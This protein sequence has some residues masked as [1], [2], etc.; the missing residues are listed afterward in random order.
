MCRLQALLKDD[1]NDFFHIEPEMIGKIAAE[2]Y[3]LTAEESPA[4]SEMLSERR[5]KILFRP[6]YRTPENVALERAALCR[7]LEREFGG[8]R[9]DMIDV[10]P[11]FE[12][13]MTGEF[14]WMA[15]YARQPAEAKKRFRKQALAG[16]ITVL[17]AVGRL[18]P[19]FI[20]GVQ[21]GAMIAALCSNPLLLEVA[22]RQRVATDSE[23]VQLRAG[24]PRVRGILAIHPYVTVAHS[25]M[26]RI[27]EALPEVSGSRRVLTCA[28]TSGPTST[29]RKFAEGLAQALGSRVLT[30]DLAGL[31]WSSLLEEPILVLPWQNEGCVACGKKAQ[32]TRCQS[33]RRPLHLTC[34]VN[35]KSP[36]EPPVCLNC[37]AATKQFHPEEEEAT[38]VTGGF[39]G[40]SFDQT[41]KTECAV[42]ASMPPSVSGRALAA[43]EWAEECMKDKIPLPA[44]RELDRE[45]GHSRTFQFE[46]F[47]PTNLRQ[48]AVQEVF[49][50]V[51]DQW[52]EVPLTAI[53]LPEVI[54]LRDCLKAAQM[55]EDYGYERINFLSKENKNREDPSRMSRSEATRLRDL[56]RRFRLNPEDGVLERITDSGHVPYIPS[57]EFPFK[58]GV[59]WRV[60]L[61]EQV[62]DSPIRGHKDAGRTAAILTKMAYW[63]GLQG[64]SEFWC[65]TCIHCAKV[66]GQ[67]MPQLM[68]VA[69]EET[70][71]G[72]WLDIYVDFQGP[73][74]ESVDGLRYLCT[75]TCRLLR[76]PMLVPCATLQKED[77]MHAI[78]TAMLRTLAIP[79]VIRHDRGKEFGSAVLEEVCTLLGIDHRMPAPHR[80]Q[81]VG[82]GETVHR[83][84]NKLLALFLNEITSSHPQDWPKALDLIFYI[85]M[86][87]PLQES[88]FCARDLDRA[89]SMRDHLERTLVKFDVGKLMA[90]QDW[91]KW[92][93]EQYLTNRSILTRYLHGESVKRAETFD[94]G[95]NRKEWKV[96]ERVCRKESRGVMSKLVPR[97]SGPFIISQVLSHHKV[98]LN[99]PDGEMAFPYPVPIAELIRVPER[100]ARV[101]PLDYE[102]L[103]AA[104]SL[105]S[106]LKNPDPSALA[107]AKSKF[108]SVGA[109]AYV[110]YKPPVAEHPK[111]VI[112]GRVIENN[113]SQAMMKIQRYEG[114]WNLSR[115]RWTKAEEVDVVRYSLI[116]REVT[117]HRDGA[118]TYSDLRAL[119]AGN[120]RMQVQKAECIQAAAEGSY[121]ALVEDEVASVKQA[122]DA[123][124]PVFG[125][126]T[127][128]SEQVFVCQADHRVMNDQGRLGQVVKPVVV[129]NQARWKEAVR[130]CVEEL[131]PL[132]KLRGAGACVSFDPG[133]RRVSSFQR[134]IKGLSLLGAAC[135]VPPNPTKE[136]SI[137][138]WLCKLLVTCDLVIL[139]TYAAGTVAVYSARTWEEMEPL[140]QELP[141]GEFYVALP[142]RNARGG[143]EACYRVEE[144]TLQTPLALQLSPQQCEFKTS[145]EPASE[146]DEDRCYVADEEE[147]FSIPHVKRWEGEPEPSVS[148]S[149]LWRS[150]AK[151]GLFA[152]VKIPLECYVGGVTECPR[153][154]VD[155]SSACLVDLT[156]PPLGAE[157]TD[158]HRKAFPDLSD[159]E[160]QAVADMIGRKAAVMWR[161]GTPQTT[162]VGFLHD[163]VVK[164]GP[165]SLP[166]ICRRGEAADWVEEKIRK[167]YA[168]GQLAPGSS[169]WGSPAFRVSAKGRKDRLVVDYRRVNALTERATFLMP[170]AEGVKTRVAG[171]RWFSTA[172][173]VAGFNQIKNTPF[174]AQ[175]LAIVSMSGKHLPTSLVFGPR[176]GPEDFSKF[177][178][179]VFRRK[180]FRTWFL[181]VDDVC[182]A[183]GKGHNNEAAPGTE[184]ERLLSTLPSEEEKK[185]LVGLG[186]E[187]S[188]DPHPSAHWS[189]AIGL[190]VAGAG[191]TGVT[192]DGVRRA[193]EMATEAQYEV[194]ETIHT[195]GQ[196]CRVTLVVL[197][198]GACVVTILRF[199]GCL[200][201]FL[202]FLRSGRNLEGNVDSR[203]RLLNLTASEA[204]DVKSVLQKLR[205]WRPAA[206]YD[207]EQ[208][209]IEPAWRAES[210]PPLERKE[211][212]RR[213]SPT[214]IPIRT[215]QPP[216]AAAARPTAALPSSYR[217]EAPPAQS[218]ELFS[219][220]VE[221]KKDVKFVLESVRVQ[222][223][224]RIQAYHFDDE[225]LAEA[226][227]NC[228]ATRIDLL[229]DERSFKEVPKTAR[230]IQRFEEQGADVR[231]VKGRNMAELYGSRNEYWGCHH[232][233]AICL[234]S[235]EHSVLWMGSCNL[236]QASEYN[237]ELMIRVREEH[238][239]GGEL[240]NG[241]LKSYVAN[242]DR[243]FEQGRP[244]KEPAVLPPAPPPP[245][246]PSRN[247]SIRFEPQ[248]RNRGRVPIP[249]A[250]GPSRNDR[251]PPMTRATAAGAAI[252]DRPMARPGQE[253]AY[254]STVSPYAHVQTSVEE[255]RGL[256]RPGLGKEFS[257]DPS[258]IAHPLIVIKWEELEKEMRQAGAT[259]YQGRPTMVFPEI[260][261]TVQKQILNRLGL[262]GQAVVDCSKGLLMVEIAVDPKDV[263]DSADFLRFHSTNL[264]ALKIAL[265]FGSCCPPPRLA[266]GFAETK[267][268]KQPGES[269]PGLYFSDNIGGSLMYAHAGPYRVGVTLILQAES[270]K[271]CSSGSNRVTY[272]PENHAIRGAF[273]FLCEVEPEQRKPYKRGEDLHPLR[274]PRNR[275]TMSPIYRQYCY[276]VNGCDPN[277]VYWGKAPGPDSD[278]RCSG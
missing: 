81:E 220:S 15:P 107:G 40:R 216:K 95:L 231:L 121:F 203:G 11:S 154:G 141:H 179:R 226:F 13:P 254:S 198:A 258:P 222:D 125:Y 61:F 224:I 241:T 232:T 122:Q 22:T 48:K 192:Y 58:A 187:F 211:V 242:F 151:E 276:L 112:V 169:P 263:P 9:I 5:V 190:V 136:E 182:V 108:A 228:P 165:I 124:P 116:V 129:R 272:S 270:G 96:G 172:D 196:V 7:A 65:S 14:Y 45:L 98:V 109:G 88:G 210:A 26:E 19:D 31:L 207:E 35:R 106:M 156:L 66:R 25:T 200:D 94:R 180:L 128:R 83:E 155:Y 134:M 213:R 52:S 269:S 36:S 142:C 49:E 249:S 255:A 175:V 266:V 114:K 153:S 176:N 68:G 127:R 193:Q 1:S 23:L 268:A 191:M 139:A 217:R 92:V 145:C 199:Q 195:V 101:P 274:L 33:C 54:G 115:V 212:V 75:Y 120:W 10:E 218:T 166:P 197:W 87:T 12:E 183:T 126:P 37:Y 64:D 111:S 46:N 239:V 278:Y 17:R 78:G 146:E 174:A 178:Y 170:S 158:E 181:F 42:V 117:L 206:L 240:A 103:S 221:F 85:M 215:A 82:Q 261:E 152:E 4:K 143:A 162:V 256:F 67:P 3:G 59:T 234:T 267:P 250:A 8:C 80:P 41:F 60:W 144:E 243:L 97:N 137:R 259:P 55:S 38:P 44:R 71:K 131:R 28:I 104:K 93:F 32:L 21:Q 57:G 6:P 30:A 105:G 238:R 53:P 79:I 90:I 150:R 237:H 118:V 133:E 130:A 160:I 113:V 223:K 260:N 186:K 208:R 252:E 185:A 194:Q 138:A 205:E 214:T 262:P 235:A 62:H 163:M 219:K 225:D 63:P 161:E 39:P 164:G 123:N 264:A 77:A 84:V 47:V 34:A 177:G 253:V 159:I 227:F 188:S 119:D 110:V 248:P 277:G 27:L 91:T 149:D 69:G 157:V 56:T 24:W 251:R 70:Y 20:V 209:R 247:R 29:E 89:W 275:C 147:E 244:I 50:K 265:K 43:A 246:E 132:L 72:A 189:T 74:P 73:F 167:D 86:T 140:C 168:R 18:L 273:C 229:V 184:L 201:L 230:V 102:T 100:V 271:V 99:K 148:V 245:P 171:S 202:S 2:D 233:K 51:V 76:V 16:I 257:S 135:F 173:G 204:R 236:T